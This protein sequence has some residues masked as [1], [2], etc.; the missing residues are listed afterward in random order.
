MWELLKKAYN[1]IMGVGDDVISKTGES[2]KKGFEEFSLNNEKFG[3]CMI[4]TLF[5]QSALYCGIAQIKRLY[6]YA[7]P[8]TAIPGIG[9]PI[10]LYYRESATAATT[11]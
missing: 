4:L 3:L 5:A 10:L 9:I 8:I 11:T 6:K 2:M 1:T 7:A